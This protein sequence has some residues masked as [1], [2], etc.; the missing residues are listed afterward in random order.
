MYRTAGRPVA[1]PRYNSGFHSKSNA[2]LLGDPQHP[3]A[4]S[5]EFDELNAEIVAEKDDATRAAKM[6]QLIELVANTWVG[7]PIIEG[8]GYWAV[9]PKLVGQF[10]AIPGRHEFG[11]VE[12]PSPI[13]PPS[14]CRFHPRCP[15]V[16]PECSRIEPVLKGVAAE[17]RV[18]CHLYA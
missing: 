2:H 10:S 4:V 9:N 15:F 17:H 8:M 11:D 13:N 16:M 12:V 7:V 18:A 1:V 6:N 3:N 5:Q 14:G